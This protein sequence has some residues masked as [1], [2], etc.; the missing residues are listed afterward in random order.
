MNGD[1][2]RNIFLSIIVLLA[3]ALYMIWT[4][5]VSG[6]SSESKEEPIE[7]TLIQRVPE[8]VLRD[9]ELQHDQ[10]EVDAGND[11]RSTILR[12]RQELVRNDPNRY[13]DPNNSSQVYLQNLNRHHAIT[14]YVNSPIK[15]Y[16]SMQRLMLLLL[17]NGY[18]VS[19]WNAAVNMLTTL[20]MSLQ[21][22]GKN[23]RDQN[24]SES[25]IG[26]DLV[27]YIKESPHVA[28]MLNGLLITAGIGEGELRD[29]IL[30]LD[31]PAEG[32]Q[33]RLTDPTTTIYGDKLLV[34][35]DWLTPEFREARSKYAGKPRP[36]SQGGRVM[37]LP[38]PGHEDAYLNALSDKNE[39]SFNR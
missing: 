25:D 28:A 5:Q 21:I 19:D 16:P 2:K 23:L 8:G 30:R 26:L 11:E 35:A 31:F 20:N 34:D 1:Q 17:E 32:I 27:Q 3:V 36:S 18:D 33:E 15:D 22:R 7:Q 6:P 9:P 4:A 39:P 10:N 12:V 37:I 14:R 13:F 38:A 24:M 29:E